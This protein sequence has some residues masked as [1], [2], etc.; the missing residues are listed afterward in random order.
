MQAVAGASAI[1]DRICIASKNQHLDVQI[2]PQD[3]LICA[4]GSTNLWCVSFWN[5]SKNC[6]EKCSVHP[7]LLT[8]LIVSLYSIVLVDIPKHR[9]SCLWTEDW[10]RVGPTWAARA[11]CHTRRFRDP[12]QTSRTRRNARE[13]ARTFAIRRHINRTNTTVRIK[14]SHINAPAKWY[15][16]LA[17][18]GFWQLNQFLEYIF[19]TGSAWYA[20]GNKFLDNPGGAAAG[21]TRE[22]VIKQIQYELMT[23]GPMTV[24]IPF[25]EDLVRYSAG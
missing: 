12:S 20:L 15:R 1:S 4:G 14:K 3:A 25:Y 6:P 19:P 11:V 10:W 2:S 23:N 18:V 21:L 7:H 13:I 24:G 8:S 17:P 16:T 9:T 22:T 5:N